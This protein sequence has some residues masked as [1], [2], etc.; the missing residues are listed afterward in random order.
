MGESQAGI[1]V[2]IV[3]T[4]SGNFTGGTPAVT[5]A[6][7][8]SS[9]SALGEAWFPSLSISFVSNAKTDAYTLLASGGGKNVT[10]GS[11][12]IVA[13]L[14]NCTNVN[15]CTNRSTNNN[16]IKPENSFSI[17]KSTS[18]VFSQVIQTTNFS[19]PALDVNNQCVKS[20]AI[21]NA[22][23]ERVKG[24]DQNSPTKPT[25]THVR[26]PQDQ[27]PAV[28]QGPVRRNADSYSVCLGALFLDGDERPAQEASAVG[29]RRRGRRRRMGK[30]KAAVVAGADADHM[31][32]CGV[33]SRFAR[34]RSSPPRMTHASPSGPSRHP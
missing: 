1:P 22:V 32:R 16:A 3:N 31:W 13:D 6:S 5:T 8:T 24:I 15:K 30:K 10:S 21:G 27:D 34:P 20:A 11:F 33:R 26:Q 18:G 9:S 2:T 23:D 28:L 25:T 17:T 4:P 7:S 12:R 14:A 29:A 19:D